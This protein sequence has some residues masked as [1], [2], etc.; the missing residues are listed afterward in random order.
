MQKKKSNVP[1]IFKWGLIL[2]VIFSPLLVPQSVTAW[3][4]MSLGIM[5]STVMNGL[6]VIILSAIGAGVSR[7][8]S[9]IKWLNAGH[10]DDDENSNT[11]DLHLYNPGDGSGAYLRGYMPTTVIPGWWN[12]PIKWLLDPWLRYIGDMD[13]DTGLI[14]FT[15]QPIKFL[16]KDQVGKCKNVP[17]GYSI[18][19]VAARNLIS[20]NER[21]SNLAPIKRTEE[22]ERFLLFYSAI[23]DKGI[24]LCPDTIQTDVQHQKNSLSG[25]EKIATAIGSAFPTSGQSEAV[26]VDPGIDKILKALVAGLKEISEKTGEGFEGLA[27]ALDRD[28]ASEVS[29]MVTVA[30]KA[31]NSGR[32][33]YVTKKVIDD[34]VKALI[35]HPDIIG[36]AKTAPAC[37]CKGDNAGRVTIKQEKENT[38]K[39]AVKLE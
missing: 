14:P 27:K 3:L 33:P 32:K 30:L 16:S 31:A 22:Q 13:M 23:L 2:A 36:L 15:T 34:I 39:D 6:A 18:H 17:D 7:V 8:R 29:E 25:I 9:N 37:K 11:V 28:I 21:L 5:N 19:G 26:N 24:D 4:Y 35:A 20:M 12:T 1:G 38:T 10:F